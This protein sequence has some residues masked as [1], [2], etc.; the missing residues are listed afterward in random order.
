MS[1]QSNE[2]L[3]ISRRGFIA[4]L[5]ALGVSHSALS[6]FSWAQDVDPNDIT[7]ADIK[8]AEKIIGLDFTD[9]DRKLMLRSLNSRRRGYEAL[10]SL[11]INNSIAPALNFSPLT[12]K[13]KV[14][15]EKDSFQYKQLRSFSKPKTEEELAFLPVTHFFLFNELSILLIVDRRDLFAH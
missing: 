1:D 10:R 8:I 3:K 7:E 15:K 14:K 5:S 4:I 9:G 11:E 6:R 2:S 13:M 12:P